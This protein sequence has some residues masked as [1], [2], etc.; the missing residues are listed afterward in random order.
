MSPSGFAAQGFAPGAGRKLAQ[1]NII[2]NYLVD[3]NGTETDGEI[4]MGKSR[5]MKRPR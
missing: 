5:C 2:G 1:I 3:N 4:G